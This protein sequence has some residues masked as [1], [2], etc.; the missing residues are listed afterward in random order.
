MKDCV[1]RRNSRT[2]VAEA[3]GALLEAGGKVGGCGKFK[4][5]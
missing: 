5:V 2:G 3:W 4:N 1:F